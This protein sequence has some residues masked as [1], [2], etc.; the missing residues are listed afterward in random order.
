[1][2]TNPPSPRV[3][4]HLRR[5]SRLTLHLKRASDDLERR[6]LQDRISHHKAKAKALSEKAPSNAL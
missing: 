2:Q 1:M 6:A 4:Y 3:L 5:V